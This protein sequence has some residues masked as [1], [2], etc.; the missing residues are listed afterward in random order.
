MDPAHYVS[1]VVLPQLDI[2]ADSGVPRVLSSFARISEEAEEYADKMF[3]S[4]AQSVGEGDPGDFADE[5]TQQGIEYYTVLATLRQAMVNL[6][7]AGLYHLFEQHQAHIKRLLRERAQE[8][9]VL[10]ANVDKAKI[11]ELRLLA[12]TVKHADGSSA[13]KLRELRPDYFVPPEL[14][15]SPLEK[16]IIAR[17]TA[18][19]NPL[20]GTDLF[21]EDAELTTY[22]NAIREYWERLR[23]LL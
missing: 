5:A 10:P 9:P 7:A 22:R 14:R 16:H 2:L 11:E 20:G 6:L 19:E 13:K 12:N 4:Y 1:Y 3:E 23:P 8:L 18:S 15:G 21:V 17:P